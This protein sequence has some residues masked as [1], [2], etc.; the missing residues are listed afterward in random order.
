MA[1]VPTIDGA[2][3]TQPVILTRPKWEG[4]KE[5]PG[6]SA[7]NVFDL[8]GVG[9]LLESVTEDLAEDV[10]GTEVEIPTKGGV[11][12]TIKNYFLRAVVIILGFIF[13]AVGL[14]MFKGQAPIIVQN[15][16]NKTSSSLKKT[17]KKAVKG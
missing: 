4:V 17:A 9:D 7:I 8:P 11:T 2:I 10:T 13:I 3:G 5:L 1:E 16:T 6:A 12:D 14:T 15:I